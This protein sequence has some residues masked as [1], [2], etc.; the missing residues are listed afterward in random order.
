MDRTSMPIE[1]ELPRGGA[2]AIVKLALG[3]GRESTLALSLR[4]RTLRIQV[5]ALPSGTALE[6]LPPRQREVAAL[7]AH[8]LGNRE[9]AKALGVRESTVACHLVRI[10]RTLNLSGRYELVSTVLRGDRS[11]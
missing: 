4:G 10:Y 3:A 8:G 5:Q 7:V 2:P 1:V 11:R 6:R 9:V